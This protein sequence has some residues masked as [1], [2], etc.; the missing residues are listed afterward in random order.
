MG[1]RCGKR[2]CHRVASVVMTAVVDI[3][4]SWICLVAMCP[5]CGF[6]SVFLVLVD[7]G[8]AIIVGCHEN[9]NAGYDAGAAYLFLRPSASFICKYEQ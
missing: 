2:H 1:L 6:D 5:L 4:N 8:N 7:A 9:D 3:L